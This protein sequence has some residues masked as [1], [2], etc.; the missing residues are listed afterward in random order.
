MHHRCA[1][2]CAHVRAHVG[3]VWLRTYPR[4]TVRALPVGVDCGRLGAQAFY[5]AKAFDANIGA[6][7]T[8]SV[9]TLAGVCAVPG[10]RRATAGV[11]DALGGAFDAAR[12]VVC[13]SA[14]TRAR[15]RTR[16]G[17]FLRGAM[18]VGMAARR[19][20]SIYIAGCVLHDVRCMVCARVCV[21]VSVFVPPPVYIA[22]NR[23]DMHVCIYVFDRVIA[24]Y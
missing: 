3:W 4:R 9:T 6:W 13:D 5:W 10:R 1:H 12:P 18:G 2:V 22:T 16:G 14:P 20:D 23:S 24:I 7:N 8:A 15:V 17:S 21:C 19:R 11:P